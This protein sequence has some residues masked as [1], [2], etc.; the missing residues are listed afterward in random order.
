MVSKHW[1]WQL[2]WSV[3]L[4]TR[5]ALHDSGIAWDC[6][7][8]APVMVDN[9]AALAALQAKHGPHN[10]P[11]MLRRMAREAAQVWRDAAAGAPRSRAA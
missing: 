8:A 7:G 5:R 1:K 10:V 9:P 4:A 11:E 3:D 2:R 6:A